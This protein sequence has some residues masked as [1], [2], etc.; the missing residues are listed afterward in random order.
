MTISEKIESLYNVPVEELNRDEVICILDE[1]KEMLN[2]GLARAAELIDGSWRVN[3]WVKKGILLAF[4][5]GVLTEFNSTALFKYFDKSTMKVR[6][7]NLNDNVRV[8]PGGSSVRD[9]CYIAKS[10]VIMPPAYINIGSYVDEGTMIDSHALVGSC[11]Q[12]GKR[13]HISAAAQVGGVLEPINAMPVII[14]DDVI[15]GGN[16][17][18]YEGTIIKKRCVLA[19][20][21]ILT[22]STQVY[23]VINQTIYKK[24]AEAPLIIPENA[25]VIPG[26][27]PL[28]SDWAKKLNLSAYTPVIIKFRDSK[29]D[30]ATTLEESLR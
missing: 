23:D 5:I 14:E 8:V 1:L 29:T 13:V 24:S 4:R 15:V 27:R 10:V 16:C 17:G 20:G 2:Q 7:F 18:I 11:A 26:S 6:Q 25:V 21:V 28:N 3:T 9:G 30:M 12:I 19:P 22:G